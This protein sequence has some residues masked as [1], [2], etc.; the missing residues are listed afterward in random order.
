MGAPLPATMVGGA[1][2][3][4]GRCAGYSKQRNTAGAVVSPML[5]NLFLHYV[6]D[7]WMR[8]KH[9]AIPFERYADD[10][11]CHCQS[12][13][14]ALELRQAL[15]QEVCGMQAA[16]APAKDQ[17]RLLQRRKSFEEV[18]RTVVRLSWLYISTKRGC[19]SSRQTLHC[20]RPS[21]QQK[22]RQE[23]AVSRSALAITSP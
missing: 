13:S 23:D 18:S 21:G 17:G 7:G 20:I 19:K 5:A 4:A 22:G 9:P 10:T 14:Q 1:C 2:E 16:T 12:E 8:R 6:F 3:Y 15:E 11:I